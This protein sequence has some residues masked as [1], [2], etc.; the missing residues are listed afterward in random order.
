MHSKSEQL[1]LLAKTINAVKEASPL[2][3]LAKQEQNR[4]HLCV[5]CAFNNIASL[6][7]SNL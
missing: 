6:E 1:Q 4:T 5:L 2:V 3:Q 7:K